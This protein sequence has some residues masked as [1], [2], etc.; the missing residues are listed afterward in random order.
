MVNKYTKAFLSSIIQ[1]STNWTEVCTKLKLSVN[2]GSKSRMRGLTLSM[3][4]DTSHFTKPKWKK[5]RDNKKKSLETYLKNSGPYI[6]S[7]QL[8]KR[9]IKDGLKEPKCECCGLDT[10]MGEPMPLELD[11]VNGNHFDN[12]IENLSI[13]CPTC[14]AIKHRNG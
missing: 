1:K 9:L 11:H 14:H 6:A 12:R 8:R 13:L 2:P 7:G 4:I 3:K 10:W 5:G